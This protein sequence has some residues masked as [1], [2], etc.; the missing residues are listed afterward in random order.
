MTVNTSNGHGQRKRRAHQKSRRGCRNCKLRRV[1]VRAL[2]LLQNYSFRSI[3]WGGLLLIIL[4]H[5]CDED[6]PGCRQCC[7]F[8][9]SCNYDP[10]APD[11]Q[12]TY[13]SMT[14]GVPTKPMPPRSPSQSSMESCF[15]VGQVEILDSMRPG[16]ICLA[17]DGHSTFMLDIESQG[18]L[19]RFMTRT[20]LSVGPPQASGVFQTELGELMCGVCSCPLSSTMLHTEFRAVSLSDAHGASH[21]GP[22]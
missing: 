1:K 22:A 15:S 18:R 14:G 20:V 12:T 13:N 19:N 2:T 7:S 10:N 11:L 4:S 16:L 6:R 21:N 5:K 8:G 9:V 3:S 17:D